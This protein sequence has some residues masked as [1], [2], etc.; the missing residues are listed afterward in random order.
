MKRGRML[1]KIIHG[2]RS[3]T[4]KYE[5]CSGFS[6]C[7][8]APTFQLA[9]PRLYR[10]LSACWLLI[11]YHP[12][13]YSN[14][15]FYVSKA[16]SYPERIGYLTSRRVLVLTMFAFIAL[17][18]GLLIQASST[19]LRILMASCT[20]RHTTSLSGTAALLLL[21]TSASIP[22]GNRLGKLV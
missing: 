2:S 4:N 3:A 9:R 12:V 15:K 11:S 16:Y 1:R 21:G 5:P 20:T 17:V 13:C 10:S 7:I 22:Q 18:G 8:W 6:P 14:E 19:P